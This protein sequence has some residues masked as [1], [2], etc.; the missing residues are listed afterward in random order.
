MLLVLFVIGFNAVVLLP[1]LTIPAPSLNDEVLHLTVTQQASLAIQQGKDPT[2]FWFSQVG[3]G[4]PLFHHYQHLPQTIL[5][6]IHRVASCFISLARLFDLSRYILLVFYPLVIFWAMRRFGFS[7]LAGGI[8]ALVSCLISTNGLFGLEYG[9]YIWRGTGLYTQLWAMFFLPL[10]LAELYRIIS[11]KGSLFWPVFLSTIV[12]LSNLLYGYILFLSSI[13]FVFLRFNKKEIASRAK[14]LVL[15]FFLIGLVTSYFWIPF[16][17][18][19]TY[20]NRSVWVPDFQYSSFGAI[21]VLGDLFKGKLLDYARFPGLTILFFISLGLLILERKKQHF[22][23]LL[24]LA[25]LFLILFFGRPTWGVLLNLLPFGRQL[26]LHRF[27]GGFHLGAVMIIGAGISVMW[28]KIRERHWGYIVILLVVFTAILVPVYGERIKFCADNKLWR[29]E[30]QKAFLAVQDELSDI[31]KTLEQLPPG[32]VFAGL[33]NTW[34]NYPYYQIG[35]VP[36]YAILTQWGIDSFGYAYHAQA[37]TDDV[38]LHFDDTQPNQ[39]NLFNIRYVL[40]HKTWSAPYYY[41]QIKEFENYI[42][43]EVSTTGYFDLVDANAVFY[44]SASD[45]YQANSQW[46]SSSLVEFKQHPMLE[47]TREPGQTFNIPS[48]S[49][50]EVN[51]EVLL[52]LAQRQPSGGRI[53]KEEAKSQSYRAE[54]EVNRE[55]YLMLKV[56]YHPGWRV[57]LDGKQV[58]PV[59]LAPGFIGVAVKPGIHQALFV[60]KSPFYRLPLLIFGIFVLLVIFLDSRKPL[61]K[62]SL[63]KFSK[64]L[65]SGN[66]KKGLNIIKK[67]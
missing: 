16:L 65:L 59:M 58:F 11:K 2:D 50:K 32:R 55:A 39:Y 18:D 8:A 51:K 49:F 52:N 7:Y 20:L 4:Y 46:L 22:R 37:L 36:F 1:E 63:K 61:L 48:F 31:K 6:I 41:E 35:S 40:L 21:K 62:K 29:T 66:P 23:A 60:Y 24:C 25:I 33:S 14:R 56:N 57:E 15:V 34:G 9:S 67:K 26:H 53:L 5:A 42:L 12:L 3:L 38:R 19:K 13:L 27:I 28:Q 10:A 44:G 30:N 64:N 17:L 54:F 47:I 45:F 43:Y